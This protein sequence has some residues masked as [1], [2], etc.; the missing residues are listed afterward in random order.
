VTGKIYAAD[1]G[2]PTPTNLTAAIGKMQTAY[3]DAAG[4]TTPDHS[5]LGSGAIGGLTL[6]PGLYKW[7]TSVTIPTD[8]TIR[9]ARA[10]PGSSR[11][12]A[13]SPSLRHPREKSDNTFYPTSPFF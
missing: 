5:E 10:T 12:R 7:S 13:I 11:S 2:F 6:A 1:Y 8:L 3:T 4:R 9:A